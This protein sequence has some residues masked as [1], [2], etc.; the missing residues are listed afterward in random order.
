MAENN[1]ILQSIDSNVALW[2]EGSVSDKKQYNIDILKNIAKNLAAIAGEETGSDDYRY[3]R[4]VLNYID[5]T[6]EKIKEG[7]GGGGGVTVE[8]L[9]VTENG[10]YT[11]PSGKAHT[12]QADWRSALTP[13]LWV[14]VSVEEWPEW[15]Q[16]AGAHDA[17]AYGAKVTHNNSHWISEIETNVYEPGVYGWVMA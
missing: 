15:V 12:S 16:P 14:A 10:T 5:E 1:D 6:V 3:I 8:P 9:A 17:Y 7:G 4:D 2:A 13:A 11:A